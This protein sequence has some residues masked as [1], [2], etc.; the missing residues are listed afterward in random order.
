[1]LGLPMGAGAGEQPK[2]AKKAKAAGGVRR[3]RTSYFRLIFYFYG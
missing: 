1:M 3:M 2:A